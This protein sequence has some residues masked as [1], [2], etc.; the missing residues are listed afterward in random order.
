MRSVRSAAWFAAWAVETDSPDA[1][2]AARTAKAM[3]SDALFTCAGQ[4]V[5]IHGGIG[6]TWEHDAHLYMRRATTLLHY[7][8]AAGAAED[9]T[10][11]TR[12]GVVREKAIELMMDF[13]IDLIVDEAK[14][15]ADIIEERF[16]DRERLDERRLVERDVVGDL[17][18]ERPGV[19]HRRP[20]RGAGRRGE[21]GRGEAAVS[22]KAGSTTTR[23]QGHRHRPQAAVPGLPRF[24]RQ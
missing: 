12:Q 18:R 5:Q 24:I 4:S 13:E 10:D 6:F 20:G 3:A 15:A 23:K 11:L 19:H 21:G 8:D 9:L 16:K 17:E 22:G 1:R 7:L 14:S 2:L